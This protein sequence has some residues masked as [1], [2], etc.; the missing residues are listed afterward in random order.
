MAG[1]QYTQNGGSGW[2]TI[3]GSDHSIVSH[4]ITGLPAGNYTFA[5]RAV[6]SVGATASDYHLVTVF[7]LPGAPSG[8]AAT[9]GDTQVGL[10]WNELGDASVNKFQLSQEIESIKLISDDRAD[11]DELGW[12][13]A[14]DGDTL[15]IGALGDDDGS[16]LNV[17]AAYVFTRVAGGWTQA[18]KLTALVR[19]KDARLRACGRR[20]W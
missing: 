13:V 12:S 3:L 1:Y 14:V 16:I 11:D 17:G 10:T 19:R 4:T 9:A 8:L 2:T 5:V 15:V 7:A 6:N 18:G 20:A